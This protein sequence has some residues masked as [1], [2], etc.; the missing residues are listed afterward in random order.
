MPGW[1]SKDVDDV[2]DEFVSW[3]YGM[4]LAILMPRMQH[5]QGMAARGV[6]GLVFPDAPWPGKG[7]PYPWED[8]VGPLP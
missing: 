3:R 8:L 4:G 7:C 2:P 5:E 6:A 1:V